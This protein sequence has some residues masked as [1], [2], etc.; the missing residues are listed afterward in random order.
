M[1]VRQVAEL[2]VPS[3]IVFVP[4]VKYKLIRNTSTNDNIPDAFIHF[5]LV[6]VV[7]YHL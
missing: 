4:L 1:D 7:Y 3:P 2:K 5:S 6:R